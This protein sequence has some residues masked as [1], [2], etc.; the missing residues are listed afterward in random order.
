MTPD[1]WDASIET[2]DELIDDQHRSLFLLFDRVQAAED[3]RD[4]LMRTLE[5]LSSYVAMHFSMEEE[6]M[7]RSA[8][9]GYSA[10]MTSRA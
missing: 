9:R 7:A 1:G 2:G 3:S 10:R 8:Q 5:E 6:L 4:E